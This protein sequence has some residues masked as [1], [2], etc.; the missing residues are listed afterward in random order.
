VPEADPHSVPGRG[1]FAVAG[2][3][4]R[5][6]RR[7]RHPAGDERRI[8]FGQG[9]PGALLAG[10]RRRPAGDAAA[11]RGPGGRRGPRRLAQRCRAA[12][13]GGPAGPPSRRW[14]RARRDRRGV[15]GAADPG[16]GRRH[17]R[18]QPDLMAVRPAGRARRAAAG[19]VLAAALVSGCSINPDWQLARSEAPSG[20]LLLDTPF[21]PQT[22]YQCGPAALATVLGASG[23][24]V[25][26]ES[27]VP[28]VYLPGREGSLQ[29]ELVAA[30]RRA[31]RI[32]YVIDPEPEALLDELRAGRPVLVL[33]N[34]L[35]RTVPRWHYAVVV[36]VDAG[37][38]RLVLNSGTVQGLEMPAPRFLRTWDWAGRWGLLSLRPGEI[39]ARADP[40][41]YLAAVAGLEQVAAAEAAGPAH[42]AGPLRRT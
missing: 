9:D 21:H 38:N 14:R 25:E 12:A 7:H 30:T 23:V 42:A 34:L 26:P 24:P 4:H 33:Q 39:P 1:P 31:G 19:L 35:V 11:G 13:A 6:C 32:P 40:V 27:L 41:R 29:L 36:G 16:A 28:Q 10:A 5:Q 3:Q 2:R 17:Q 22:E 20:T 8:A 37:A 15:P 18:L